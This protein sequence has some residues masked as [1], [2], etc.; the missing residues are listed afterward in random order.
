MLEV[1]PKNICTVINITKYVHRSVITSW[2]VLD[3]V[4]HNPYIIEGTSSR[5]K[6]QVGLVSPFYVALEALSSLL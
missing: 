2:K 4:L 5:K 1:H 6:S 3:V